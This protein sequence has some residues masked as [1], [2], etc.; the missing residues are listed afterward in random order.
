M[1]DGEKL[2]KLFREEQ[3]KKGN[4]GC[5][6]AS[7]IGDMDNALRRF[8]SAKQSKANKDDYDAKEH[9]SRYP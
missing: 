8:N 3:D 6:C 9:E 5:M 4:T 1:K 7:C 2:L